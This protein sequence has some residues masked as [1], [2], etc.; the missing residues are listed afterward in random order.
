MADGD[1]EVHFFFR[2][3]AATTLG[4][5]QYYQFFGNQNGHPSRCMS[6]VEEANTDC[7]PYYSRQPIFPIVYLNRWNINGLPAP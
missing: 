6:S 4:N 3:Y 7:V 5:N 1:M 2:P